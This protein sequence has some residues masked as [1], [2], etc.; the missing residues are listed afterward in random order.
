MRPKQPQSEPE[1][2]L[3]RARL[4]NLVDPRH[5]LVRL[6]GLIDWG[7]F[8]A[9][10]DPLY[11][12]A[13]GRPGLPT[14][15]MVGLHLLKHMDALSDEAVCARYIDSPYVQLFCGETYF[16]HALP[17]DRSSMTRWRQRIGA[18]RLEVLLAESLAAAQRGGAVD[19]K[20][21]RRVTIDTTV[22]PKAVTHPTDSKLLHRGIEIL[23]RL[24][25]RQGIR[26]RQSY[27][28]VAKRARREAAKLI[29]SGRPRQA[30]R[31]VRQLRT[32]LGRLF[33]D[34]GRKIAGSAAAKATFAEPLDLIARLLRQR[35]ED[36]GREKLYS[37]H[38][39]EV[40]C[41]GKGKAHA[42]FEFGVKVSLATANAAAP[43]G[44]FVLGARAL[45]GNPYDGHTL[46]E[47]IAQTERITGVEVERAYVDRGYRGHDAD[48]SRVILAGQKRGSTPTIRRERRR[49]NAIEPVIGHMK[50]D[51]HLG[52]N[53]LADATGDATNVILAAAGHNLRLLRAWLAWLLASLISRLLATRLAGRARSPQPVSG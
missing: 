3:F 4:Q 53:F 1:E 35:R 13:I 47:Q 6:A 16:Q 15:L 14:R 17:L 11:T 32:W 48:K 39:P 52:R 10:F 22:Q 9:E 25:R 28:R 51:G 12:D 21:C 29:Y 40:E 41:I 7:R 34:I 18:E 33:R 8:E 45:P 50:S 44:Q 31:H 38:A 27:L 19:E 23:V 30:E 46:A 24:A 43:G 26:L 20:H 36:G 5:P 42:R 2:D 37:L 49:R